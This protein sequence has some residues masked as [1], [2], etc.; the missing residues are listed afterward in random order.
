MKK[1]LLV[2]SLLLS[3]CY[4]YAPYYGYGGGAGLTCNSYAVTEDYTYID[5]Y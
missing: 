3:G 4:A 5:C 2:I 1:L